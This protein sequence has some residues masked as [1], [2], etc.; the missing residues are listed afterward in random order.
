M[1]VRF[2][3]NDAKNAAYGDVAEFLDDFFFEPILLI[4]KE[5]GSGRF[6]PDPDAFLPGFAPDL[7]RPSHVARV[8][9]LN[10]VV[11]RN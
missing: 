10:L 2:T 9:S 7:D 8:E 1:L 6:R 4:P 11:N 5:C 3:R